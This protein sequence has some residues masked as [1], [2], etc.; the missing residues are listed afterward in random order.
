MNP[1][2]SNKSWTGVSRT[3]TNLQGLGITV[4]ELKD[5]KINGILTLKADVHILIDSRC[6]EDKFN[7]FSENKQI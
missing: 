1:F 3:C 7:Q 2:P 5:K 4:D 6:S